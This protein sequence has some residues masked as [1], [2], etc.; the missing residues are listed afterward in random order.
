MLSLASLSVFSSAL[1]PQDLQKPAGSAAEFTSSNLPIIVINTNGQ[2]IVD[3]P[4]ITADMGII[5]NGSA[6]NNVTDSYNGYNGKIGIELRGQTSQDFPKKPYAVELRDTLGNDLEASI[7]GMPKN[8]DWILYATYNDKTF[9]RDILIYSLARK[10]GW[11]ASRTRYCELVLN[12]EYMGVYVLMEKIKRGKNRVNIA[13]MDETC[14]AGDELTGG[15]IIKADKKDDD[16]DSWYSKYPGSG[17]NREF[18]YEYPKT[19]DITEEQ[20]AYIKNYIDTFED[21]LAGS[22]F[23]DTLNGYSKYIDVNS[24]IDYMLMTEFC[25]NVDGFRISTYMYKERDSKGGKLFMGPLWDYNNAFGN[26]DYAMGPYSTGWQLDFDPPNP[27]DGD[28][29][30]IIFW[31]KR[32]LEDKAFADKLNARWFRLRGTTLK[33]ENITALMD[34]LALVVDEAKERNFERWPILDE[35]VWPN[36]YIWYTYE[37]EVNYLKTWIED[38]LGW[39]DENMFGETIAVAEEPNAPMPKA[40]ALMQ[41][42]PNPFNP[43][44]VIKYQL[45]D[46]ARVTLKVYDMLGKEIAILADETQEAGYHSARFEGASLAAGVYFYSLK[47][48]S[49]TATK[50]ML[51]LK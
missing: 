42:Y 4:K 45:K 17:Y 18:I 11:Y 6:R 13:K 3:E 50:K 26:C 27:P 20:K 39:M 36:P 41:N 12:G 8:E 47:A 48:G 19:E 7:L 25:K 49:Y 51:L 34:S 1:R 38:R 9:M 15:Y 2:E 44:T 23:A 43:S 30:E 28:K 22:N 40:Y 14:I 16:E 46:A 32:L 37:G 21:V 10:L 5:D 35:I 31:F 24:F 33:Y 29:R